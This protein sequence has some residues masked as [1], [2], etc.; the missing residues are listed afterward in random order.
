MPDGRILLTS[1]RFVDTTFPL[2]V[3]V[4]SNV[5][6]RSEFDSMTRGFETYFERGERY[7]VLTYTPEG[8]S[9]PDARYRKLI[10]D[11][12]NEPRVRELSRKLC[13]GSATVVQSQLVRGA[14]TAIL[15]LWTPPT[16]H[17]I[18]GTPREGVEWCLDRL[19]PSGISIQCSREQMQTQLQRE[20]F[21]G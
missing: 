13:V 11:W 4:G 2:V 19:L 7:A 16:P 21:S 10:A 14:L 9:L 5:Y 12:A 3:A 15:W 1:M 17:R 18:V 8:P 6:D 20:A